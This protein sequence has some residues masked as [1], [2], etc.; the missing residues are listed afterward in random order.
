VTKPSDVER[1]KGA[2]CG[3]YGGYLH[4]DHAVRPEFFRPDEDPLYKETPY[5]MDFAY[6]FDPSAAD[7]LPFMVGTEVSL[8]EVEREIGSVNDM[9]FIGAE[10][11]ATVPPPLE[12]VGRIEEALTK[13]RT[14]KMS[15]ERLEE[16][17]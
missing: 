6:I 11:D 5:M 16:L 2:D 13:C 1:L 12:V 8:E 7:H 14:W 17:L 15:R 9:R 10:E 4:T 3:S